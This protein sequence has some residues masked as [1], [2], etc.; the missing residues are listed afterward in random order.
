MRCWPRWLSLEWYVE[1]DA[2]RREESYLA[3]R[4]AEMRA[5][6]FGIDPEAEERYRIA[7]DAKWAQQ[8][9]ER[10]ARC[11]FRDQP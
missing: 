3:A 7:Q 9:R 1:K 6:N 5:N 11:G 4:L 2:A 10:L 8:E